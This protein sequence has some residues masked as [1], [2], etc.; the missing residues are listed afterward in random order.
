[1]VNHETFA[2]LMGVFPTGVTIVTSVHVDGTPRGATVNAFSSISQAPPICMVAI[3]KQSLT[4]PAVLSAAAFAINF[5]SI[6]QELLSRRFASKV[7]DSDNSRPA[8]NHW[9][10]CCCRMRSSSLHRRW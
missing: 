2:K 10:C 9:R 3:S 6:D 4:V 1:M 8:R 5:L 7:L